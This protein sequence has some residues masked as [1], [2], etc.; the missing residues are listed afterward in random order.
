MKQAIN[1]LLKE[2]GKLAFEEDEAWRMRYCELMDA[3]QACIEAIETGIE[4]CKKCK[5]HRP[6]DCQVVGGSFYD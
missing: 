3:Y 5:Q 4:A 1:E 2:V 6:C